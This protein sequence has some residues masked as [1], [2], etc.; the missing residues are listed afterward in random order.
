M[1]DTLF[2]NA[3]WKASTS[4]ILRHSHDPPPPSGGHHST[5]LR[6]QTSETTSG[7]SAVIARARRPFS[8]CAQHPA[9]LL[10]PVDVVPS[11][12]PVT[13]GSPCCHC[14]DIT[15]RLLV[16]RGRVQHLTSR[17]RRFVWRAKCAVNADYHCLDHFIVLS[18]DA[19]SYL[20]LPS[21]P[22]DSSA[23]AHF[24]KP[25]SSLG[26]LLCAAERNESEPNQRRGFGRNKQQHICL[27]EASGLDACQF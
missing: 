12:G 25:R 8:F 19:L 5:E 13:E 10:G 17:H 3:V 24:L 14:S 23:W 22:F 20:F 21:F 7:S 27:N 11:N 6:R 18:H 2:I 26:E 15:R 16:T 4:R 1:R 9:V